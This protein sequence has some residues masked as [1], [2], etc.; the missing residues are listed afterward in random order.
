MTQLLELNILVV[1]QD[2]P[3][4]RRLISYLKTLHYDSIR[5]TNDVEMMRKFIALGQVDVVIIDREFS[6]G[7]MFQAMN[8]IRWNE[9]F[10]NRDI[11]FIVYSGQPAEE[12]IAEVRD[13]GANE[14]LIA[15]LKRSNVVKVMRGALFQR[16]PFIDCSTFAGPC[17]R[18]NRGRWKLTAEHAVSHS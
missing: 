12:V 1:Q 3:V 10:P 14:I 11:P 5:T 18:V 13:A 7:T 15:P 2:S 16:R 9:N 17:R 6:D 4:R 8:E